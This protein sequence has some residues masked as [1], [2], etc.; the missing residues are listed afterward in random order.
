MGSQPENAMV[1]SLISGSYG[2]K[3]HDV[4]PIAT[5]LAAPLLRGQTVR[6]AH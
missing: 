6:V 5:M 3:P 4:P 1:N 2:G